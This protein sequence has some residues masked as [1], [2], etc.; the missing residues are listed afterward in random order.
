MQQFAV[1]AVEVA[2]DLDGDHPA[3][4]LE[5]PAALLAALQIEG[6]AVVARQV[7]E[8]ARHAVP[9][10]VGGHAA[11]HALVRRQADRHEVRVDR[12]DVATAVYDGADAVMLSAESASGKHPVA[13][14]GIMNRIIAETERDPLYRNLIDAQHQA[15]LPAR[16]DAIC[17]ALRDV[18]HI[19]GAVAT[20]TY[21]SSGKTS[22][23]A[24]RERPRAP[25]VNITPRLD[26]A[27]RLALAWGVHSTVSPDVGN[28][29]AMVEAA[30]GAAARE[31]FAAAGDPIAITAGMPFGQA[32]TTN[33][34][35]LAEIGLQAGAATAAAQ[36]A[37]MAQT[38]APSKTPVPA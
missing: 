3:V 19:L 30:C 12:S 18:T 5:V 31:G 38:D 4:V 25:I 21:T 26:T 6:Q 10:E 32:G 8:R 13:A 20:V 24:A 15:P 9:G 36:T 33:L 34:L 7:V 29:D 23:R 14:V 27:R 28:V 11:H 22:L 37:Q 35:R 2:A 1:V 17:A 16:Q